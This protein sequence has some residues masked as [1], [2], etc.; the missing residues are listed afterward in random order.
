VKQKAAR[1]ILSLL[2]RE[3]I[4]HA[5]N[6]NEHPPLRRCVYAFSFTLMFAVSHAGSNEL[7]ELFQNSNIKYLSIIQ[8]FL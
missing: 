2:K 5:T 8:K 6:K 1:L 7:K 3:K 4:P